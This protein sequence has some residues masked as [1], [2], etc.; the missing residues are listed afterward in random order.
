[1][2]VFIFLGSLLAAMDIGVPIAYALL[3]SGAALM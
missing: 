1:M 3:V 2:T